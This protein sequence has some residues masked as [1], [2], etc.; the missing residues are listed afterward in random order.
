MIDWGFSAAGP[1]SVRRSLTDPPRVHVMKL[2]AGAKVSGLPAIIAQVV[3]YKRIAESKK[4][5]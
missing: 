3:N 2:S 5:F 4:S 1:E